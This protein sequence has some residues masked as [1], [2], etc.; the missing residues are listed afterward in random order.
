MIAAPCLPAAAQSTLPGTAVG[1][2]G[3]PTPAA[4]AVGVI[5]LAAIVGLFWYRRRSRMLA[6][7]QERLKAE[8]GLLSTALDSAPEGFFLWRGKVDEPQS[9]TQA[10]IGLA[11]LL[12]QP[13]GRAASYA[14]IGS[15]LSA[16]DRGLLDA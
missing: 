8:I 13:P 12:G 11:A 15:C 6:A 10:S 16:T 7:E 5:A 14:A 4:L 1:E 2:P 3:V 9:S